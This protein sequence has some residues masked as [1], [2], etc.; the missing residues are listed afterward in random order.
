MVCK[1][2]FIKIKTRVD[3]NNIIVDQLH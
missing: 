1:I 2:I 3:I